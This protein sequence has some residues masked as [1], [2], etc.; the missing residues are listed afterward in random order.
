MTE[1]KTIIKKPGSP[2]V[3]ELALEDK[4][5]LKSTLD[6]NEDEI[7]GML[8]KLENDLTTKKLNEELKEAKKKRG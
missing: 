2:V 1:K 5:L 3:S 6:T 8:E 4:L 7:E